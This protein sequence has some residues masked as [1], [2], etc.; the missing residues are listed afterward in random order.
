V[1]RTTRER[2]GTGPALYIQVLLPN[3]DDFLVENF[4]HISRNKQ[5]SS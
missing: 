4:A 2:A 5:Q 3:D 1:I